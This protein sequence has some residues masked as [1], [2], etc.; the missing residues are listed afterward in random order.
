MD[1]SQGPQLG[2]S[3]A[4]REAIAARVPLR[5]SDNGLNGLRALEYC[6]RMRGGTQAHLMRCSDEKYYVV[7]FPN[8]P[9]GIRILANELLGGRL[10][11]RLVLPLAVAPVVT[12]D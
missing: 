10:A 5:V 11:A 8:N 6:R 12:V 1:S 4:T 3:E 9:Q 7:K 2:R